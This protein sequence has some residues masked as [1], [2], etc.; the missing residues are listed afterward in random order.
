MEGVLPRHL[1]TVLDSRICSRLESCSCC[2]YQGT[3]ACRQWL[4]VVSRNYAPRCNRG[5]HVFLRSL[6]HH[7]WAGEEIW[8]WGTQIG[9]LHRQ[10]CPCSRRRGGW[11]FRP[12]W[13]CQYQN[14]DDSSYCLVSVRF[15]SQDA[16]LHGTDGILQG[17]IDMVCW[18]SSD[19]P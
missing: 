12:R 3:D 15:D 18:R 4:L 10:K 5:H 14:L 8:Y 13:L 6:P 19:L 16:D 11:R 17:V 2:L 1:E 7:R 9:R